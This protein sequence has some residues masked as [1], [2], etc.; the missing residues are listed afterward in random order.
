MGWI[1]F[2]GNFPENYIKILLT[3]GKEVWYG[4]AWY[5]NFW[6]ECD[7][8]AYILEDVTHWMHLPKPPNIE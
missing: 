1:K 8:D 5:G 3:D 6:V 4:Y 2:D 7:D